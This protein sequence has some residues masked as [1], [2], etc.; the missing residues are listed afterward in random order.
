[1]KI[2]VCLAVLFA[3]SVAYGAMATMPKSTS[4]C[5][6]GNQ[7]CRAPRDGVSMLQTWM[8]STRKAAKTKM[9]TCGYKDPIPTCSD[10][11]ENDGCANFYKM[12]NGQ[13]YPCLNPRMMSTCRSD[14]G[15]T[16]ACM[17][18]N[19]RDEIK[20]LDIAWGAAEMLAAKRLVLACKKVSQQKSQKGQWNNQK[21]QCLSEMAG[22]KARAEGAP[23]MWK[24]LYNFLKVKGVQGALQ[25]SVRDTGECK[26]TGDE[27]VTEEECQDFIASG[28]TDMRAWAKIKYKAAKALNENYDQVFEAIVSLFRARA[29]HEQLTY[30]YLK[31][32]Y[33]ALKSFRLR[34]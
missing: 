30:G 19:L 10:A 34:F 8:S 15:K 32:W 6:G 7:S 20:D 13:A 22:E 27:I 25:N 9:P 1:M 4:T 28:K 18:Q 29:S 33:D 14:T 21:G 23:K 26:V 5:P 24:D 16:G 2:S 31:A 11:K 12:K 17:P 3:A